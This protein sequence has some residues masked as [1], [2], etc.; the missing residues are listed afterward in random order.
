MGPSSSRRLERMEA[1]CRAQG[2]TLT[3]SR[4]VVLET[5][6]TLGTHPTADE[7]FATAAV[8]EPGIGRATVYRALENFAQVGAVAKAA[9]MGTAVRYDSDA[10]R[11]H[12]L[13]CTRCD[14]IIDF[15]DP[16]FDAIAPPD[17]SSWGFSVSEVQVQ[18][19]GTC[20]DCLN[21]E[22]KP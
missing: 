18:F 19:R 7:V 15:R 6:A 20:Q 21:K 22:E 11:H 10:S 12:H 4:R 9:H 5:L 3:P 8:R 1:A 16:G 13:V 2:L 17:T 14:A